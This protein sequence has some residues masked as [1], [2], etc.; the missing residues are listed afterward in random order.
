[1]PGDEAVRRPWS[2]EPNDEP[3]LASPCAVHAH[4]TSKRPRAC[5]GHEEGGVE[6]EY[7]AA[8]PGHEGPLARR[9][10]LTREYAV[11]R[12]G[13]GPRAPLSTLCRGALAATELEEPRPGREC[14]R[15]RPGLCPDAPGQP[16]V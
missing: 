11:Q 7:G 5:S 14:G 2:S 12:R 8:V 1:M 6:N 10:G 16:P 15:G 9:V 3:V 4:E 13:G